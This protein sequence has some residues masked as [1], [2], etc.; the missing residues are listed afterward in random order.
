MLIRI[1]VLTFHEN[2][3]Q[4]FL[5]LFEQHAPQIKK[6]P[7]CMH[8]ALYKD[9]DLYGRFCVHSVWKDKQDLENYRSSDFFKGLWSKMKV[10]FKEK[11]LA[12]S[13]HLYQGVG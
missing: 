6:Y 13:L 3:V 7:G 4:E 9:I 8:L 11:A 10:L 5:A 1:V 12:F 2:T